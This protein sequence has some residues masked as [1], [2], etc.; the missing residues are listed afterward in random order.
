MTTRRSFI[1]AVTAALGGSLLAADGKAKT[2]LLMSAWDTVNIGD[3]GHTPGTLHILEQHLPEVNVI[4][5]ARKLDERVTAM[6]KARFPKVVLLQGDLAGKS[7]QD[8]ALR[9]AIGRCDLFIRNSGMGQDTAWMKY[10]K[11]LDK[12]YGVYGQSYFETMVTGANGPENMALLNAA[13][14]I[15]TR[16]SRTLKMLQKA[17]VKCPVLEFGPDGCFGIDVLDEERGLATMKK[18]GLED[19]KFITVLLRTNTPKAPGVDD[20]RPQKLNPLHPTPEQVADD[21]RRAGVFRELITKWVQTTGNKVLIAPETF[22]EM[23]HNKR[24]IFDPLPP[25]IQK[26]VVNLEYFWNAD[27]AASVFARAHTVVCHEPHSPIIAL[28]NGTPIIHAFSEFHGLK[29]WMFEDIGLKEWLLEFDATP[30]EALFQ[31]VM[32]IDKDYPAAL[33]KVKKAMD[34]V[35]QRQADTMKVA[36]KVLA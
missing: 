24:L 9:A 21:E 36:G 12:P 5:W 13:S 10:C 34:F 23:G 33:A 17:G 27:E 29:C 2:V 22:K 11:E 19:R 35:R 28:A 15:Y 4:V 1:S 18:L 20:N 14:F 7:P 32:T 3:I 25:E 6:L 8:E 16:E 30:A 26:Q 31:T